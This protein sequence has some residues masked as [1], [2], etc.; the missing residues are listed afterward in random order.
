MVGHVSFFQGMMLKGFTHMNGSDGSILECQAEQ[1]K[2][3]QNKTEQT[4]K[5]N[6]KKTGF[7]WDL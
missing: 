6:K 7:G 5:I 1:N 3:K 2:T 4:K